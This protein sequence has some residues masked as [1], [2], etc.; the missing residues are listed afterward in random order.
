MINTLL[1]ICISPEG[2]SNNNNEVNFY[3]NQNQFQNKKKFFSLNKKME[4]SNNNTITFLSNNNYINNY[5]KNNFNK[6]YNYNNFINKNSSTGKRSAF[7]KSSQG[8]NRN[9]LKYSNNNELFFNRNNNR[10]FN[11]I[12]NNNQFNIDEQKLADIINYFN[13]YSKNNKKYFNETDYILRKSWIDKW[14]NI[15]KYSQI[16]RKEENQKILEQIKGK[17]FNYNSLLESNNFYNFRVNNFFDSNEFIIIDNELY[18]KFNNLYNFFANEV[19]SMKEIFIIQIFDNHK[20]YYKYNK[21]INIFGFDLNNK[22]LDEQINRNINLLI[23]DLRKDIYDFYIFRGS[24][25]KN[26][27]KNSENV[28][29]EDKFL[30]YFQKDNLFKCYIRKDISNIIKEINL[31]KNIDSNYE[32]KK[33]DIKF[34]PKLWLKNWKKS[35]YFDKIKNE[36]DKWNILNLFLNGIPKIDNINFK[37][38]ILDIDSFLNN[39][40]KNDKTNYIV[41]KD[42]IV[43]VKEDIFKAFIQHYGYD[44]DYRLFEN[45]QKKK[46]IIGNYECD[47]YINSKMLINF[48]NIFINIINDENNYNRKKIDIINIIREM[49]LKIPIKINDFYFKINTTNTNIFIFFKKNNQYKNSNIALNNLNKN[50]INKNWIKYFEQTKNKKNKRI[51]SINNK[52]ILLI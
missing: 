41:S 19:I 24:E 26:L 23:D 31:I 50:A 5:D 22:V 13:F 32:N 37:E 45:K 4:I 21:K 2:F 20:I 34:L 48:E 25:A 17:V 10:Y 12:L 15:I 18:K 7:E 39:G 8:N 3:N 46:I 36:R 52:D 6:S 30:K 43:S 40:N 14:K 29:K 16:K 38:I 11:I 9:N 49:K 47:F 33:D 28:E 1:K 27:F 44:I 35:I 51:Y 42:K